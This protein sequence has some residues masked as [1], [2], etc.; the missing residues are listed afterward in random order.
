VSVVGLFAAGNRAGAAAVFP[1][2]PS[3]SEGAAG[4]ARIGPALQKEER[5]SWVGPEVP[6]SSK[7][8]IF[9][10]PDRV[11]VL[12]AIFAGFRNTDR[13]RCIGCFFGANGSQP[14]HQ[15]ATVVGRDP[16]TRRLRRLKLTALINVDLFGGA[17]L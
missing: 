15:P 14:A 7:R 8:V 6:L 3:I 1:S 5:A 12:G 4:C 16:R 11:I 2:C 17:R 13:S 9:A 10:N